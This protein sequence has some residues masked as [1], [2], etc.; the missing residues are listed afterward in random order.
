M[1]F[2]GR[3]IQVFLLYLLARL[4]GARCLDRQSTAALEDFLAGMRDE[5]AVERPGGS[6]IVVSLRNLPSRPTVVVLS[7]SY[8]TE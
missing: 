2:S 4:G 5:F 6:E 3:H 1:F 8:L 7:P